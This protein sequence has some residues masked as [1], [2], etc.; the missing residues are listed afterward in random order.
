MFFDFVGILLEKPIEDF[1]LR[2]KAKFYI[3]RFAGLKRHLP[4][5]SNSQISVHSFGLLK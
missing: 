5:A 1:P 4:V 2:I 3:F